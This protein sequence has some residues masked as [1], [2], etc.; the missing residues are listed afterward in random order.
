M[1]LSLP[2]ARS[3]KGR[4]DGT[5]PGPVASKLRVG[6]P[7][8]MS[9]IWRYEDADGTEVASDDAPAPQPFPTQSDAESWLGETWRELLEAGGVQGTLLQGGR[10]VY[11][12]V[13]LAA[14]SPGP[15]PRVPPG[16]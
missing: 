6:S 15:P 14:Q 4:V 2:P 16:A 11:R 12:P 3:A 10:Q 1:E 9:W 13:G 5:M 8:D 7:S